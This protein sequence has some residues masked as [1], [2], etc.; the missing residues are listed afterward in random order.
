MTQRVKPTVT[1][2]MHE[3]SEEHAHPAFG[4]ASIRRQHTTD[5]NLFM[6]NVP[7]SDVFVIEISGAEM[8][9]SL[10][11]DR[12]FPTKPLIK[13]AMTPAQLGDLLASANSGRNVPCTIQ[14]IGNEGAPLI[15]AER[16]T[17]RFGKEA[18]ERFQE[19]GK[20]LG[21]LVTEMEGKL[22]DAKVSAKRQKEILEPVEK[23]QRE[24]GSNLPFMQEQFYE[25]LEGMLDEVRAQATSFKSEDE[26]QGL[27][28]KPKQTEE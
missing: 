13:V 2:G 11:R 5:V 19:I 7:H 6:S 27:L 24:I 15:E 14:R 20:M 9:R 25:A 1:P 17:K 16:S 21:E 26:L 18:H 4:A 22:T 10:N 12:V 23:L 8:H 3:G 28:G